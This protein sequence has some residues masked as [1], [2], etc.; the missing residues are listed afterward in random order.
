MKKLL[1]LYL[2]AIAVMFAAPLTADAASLK[3]DHSTGTVNGYRVY[4]DDMTTATDEL[5]ADVNTW[6]FPALILGQEYLIGVSA[7]NQAGE[8][9][10]ALIRFTHQENIEITLPLQPVNI[11][12]NFSEP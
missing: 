5:P 7:F 9:A 8:S 11:S 6:E 4:L 2:L 1:P 10:K 12:I 3:W